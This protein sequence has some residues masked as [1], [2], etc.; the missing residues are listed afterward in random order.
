MHTLK[1]VAILSLLIALVSTRA[2]D[3]SEEHRR[4]SNEQSH[5]HTTMTEGTTVKIEIT[6]SVPREDTTVTE[7][8]DTTTASNAETTTASN[9]TITTTTAKPNPR[10]VVSA[11]KTKQQSKQIIVNRPNMHAVLVSSMWYWHLTQ[12][13]RS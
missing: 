9:E 10:C 12:V 3:S 5:E 2:R 8:M 6:T 7:K 1:I 4:D 13:R 11:N